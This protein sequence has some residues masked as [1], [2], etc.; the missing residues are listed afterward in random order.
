MEADDFVHLARQVAQD[1]L[2]VIQMATWGYI[3]AYDVNTN[4]VQ[5]VLPTFRR[6]D[7]NTGEPVPIVT[8]WI[9]LGTPWAGNGIGMQFYPQKCAA[10][11]QDPTQ[12]EQVLVLVIERTTG[13]S[14]SACMLFN[15]PFPV[16]DSSLQPG[17]GILKSGGGATLK[18]DASGNVIFQGGSTPVAVEGSRTTGHQHALTQLKAAIATY[19]SANPTCGLATPPT[20]ATTDVGADLETILAAADTDTQT[21]TVATGQGAQDVLAPS[22]G[23]H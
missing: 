13:V 5:L 10:T 17:E 4:T 12:G 9:Q 18:L 19:I 3:A 21:D 8:G 1:Q 22:A 7:P 6:A 23:G 14:V 15:N 11:P 2:G 16:I 20:G